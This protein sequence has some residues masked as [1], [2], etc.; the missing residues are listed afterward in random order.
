MDELEYDDSIEYCDED[1]D[2]VEYDSRVSRWMKRRKR[3]GGKKAPARGSVSK[4]V[5]GSAGREIGRRKRSIMSD[6]KGKGLLSGKHPGWIIPHLA[7]CIKNNRVLVPMSKCRVT[8]TDGPLR[9]NYQD[10]VAGLESLIA[11]CKNVIQGSSTKEWAK[12]EA[13]AVPGAVNVD[14]LANQCFGYVVKFSD[15]VNYSR[16]GQ[17]NFSL[18]FD[19]G[20]AS[21]RTFNFG[22]TGQ[23]NI[24]EFFVLA[25]TSNGGNGEVG[26]SDA[27][28]LTINTVGQP[29]N[30]GTV[31]APP[32]AF[33]V[34]SVNEYDFNTR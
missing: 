5:K 14:L 27:L 2:E 31:A 4:L 18:T 1:G 7:K 6:E 21:V 26:R 23:D 13:P 8:T 15:P 28:R 25:F 11:S 10:S 33:T 16:H 30:D 17:L 24:Y 34:E 29:V 32:T 3:R 12:D 20:G 19:F 22:V 9:L